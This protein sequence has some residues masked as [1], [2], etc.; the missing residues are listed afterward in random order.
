MM[1]FFGETSRR[2]SV[3]NGETGRAIT[4]PVYVALFAAS[5]RVAPVDTFRHFVKIA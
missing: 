5:R 2:E 1:Y 4:S 3:R